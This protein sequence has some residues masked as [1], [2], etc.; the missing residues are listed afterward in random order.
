MITGLILRDALGKQ[1]NNFFGELNMIRNISLFFAMVLIFS[2]AISAQDDSKDYKLT[3]EMLDKQSNEL[4]Q[5][6]FNLN[7][8]LAALIK[9]Y[10]LL[11][12]T[13]IKVLPFQTN[14]NLGP[15][16]IEIEKHSFI[17]DD[18]FS[19]K[20][21]GVRTKKIVIYTN[22]E[23]VS[24]IE[25]RI[26]EKNFDSGDENVVDIVDPSP[27]TPDT[28]DIIFTHT[29]KGKVLMDKKK[30]ADVKNNTASPLRNEIK[31]TFLVPHLSLF[32]DILLFTAS[33]YYKS[34]KD[35]DSTMLEFLKK[36]AN[37]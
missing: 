11:K 12:T 34:M 5:Q 20:A 31:Q 18:K 10:D 29:Y 2:A 9:K 25:S 16:F 6:I 32:Y 15:D 1:E 33:S 17:R 7:K 24:K 37:Y 19:N 28:N 36:S 8:S 4:D 3:S 35:S 23:T 14:Y 30:F 21:T 26:F 27:Q 13:D 22:G